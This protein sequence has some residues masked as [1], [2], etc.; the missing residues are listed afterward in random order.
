MLVMVFNFEASLTHLYFFT[1][2]TLVFG[3]VD[4]VSFA[5]YALEL[6]VILLL[7]LLNFLNKLTVCIMQMLNLGFFF[8][9]SFFS[10]LL[11]IVG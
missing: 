9:L 8:F 10:L 3:V 2:H 11:A 7:L 1:Y 6:A 4:D 5:A